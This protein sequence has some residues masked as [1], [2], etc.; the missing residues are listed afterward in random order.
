MLRVALISRRQRR[1]T[2]MNSKEKIAYSWRSSSKLKSLH[3]LCSVFEYYIWLCF[4]RW[5]VACKDVCN[6]VISP[7]VGGFEQLFGPG[8]GEF[9]QKFSKN[10]NTRG[11]A[12]GGDVEASIWLVHNS[13]SE[14][15]VVVN[16]DTFFTSWSLTASIDSW[17]TWSCILA[18]AEKTLTSNFHSLLG[19]LKAINYLQKVQYTSGVL[20]RQWDFFGCGFFKLWFKHNL[21]HWRIQTQY[22]T[23]NMKLLIL[24]HK[25]QVT[26]FPRVRKAVLYH[27]FCLGS[28]YTEW[29]GL[30]GDA[31][32][33]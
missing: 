11:V 24:Y 13:C 14:C 15:D 2:L 3:K 6:L 26:I 4:K 29:K 28:T 23:M 20:L 16:C 8:R 10:S 7:R 25:N 30:V 1:Q 22:Q 33:R 21:K 32:Y 17:I 5:L 18:W 12:W 31:I 9:E 27:L 19:V